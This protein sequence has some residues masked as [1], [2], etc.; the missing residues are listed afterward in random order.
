MSKMKGSW[1]RNLVHSEPG[2]FSVDAELHR[3]RARLESAQHVLI[4]MKRWKDHPARL[5]ELLDDL[6]KALS[7]EAEFHDEDITRRES[8]I[9]PRRGGR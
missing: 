9:H 8:T 3:A 7:G 4:K 2:E 5:A 1:D 6:E